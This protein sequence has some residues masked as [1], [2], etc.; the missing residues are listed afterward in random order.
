MNKN[1]PYIPLSELMKDLT[2]E[3][4]DFIEREKKYMQLMM[5]VVAK[6]KRLGLTQAK[7]AELSEVPRTTITKIESGSRNTTIDTLMKLAQAMGSTLEIR[8]K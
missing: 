2:Q 1:L 5:D 4:R 8:F 6:R 3:E 7:L